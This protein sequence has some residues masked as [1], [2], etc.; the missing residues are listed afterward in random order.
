MPRQW[1]AILVLAAVVVRIAAAVA[2][3]NRFYFADET[4]YFDAAGRLLQGQGFGVAYRQAPAY[5]V[6]L[7]ALSVALPTSVLSL[8]VAQG[9]LGGLGA[10]V[11]F[12]ITER[13]AGRSPAL[14]AAAIYA[15]DPL[16]VVSAGLLYPETAAA[17]LLPLVVLAALRGS[18]D[19]LLG[20]TLVGILLG[21]TALLRP[22]ALILVPVL[23]GWSALAAEVPVRR[24]LAHL[25]VVLAGTLLVLAP[26]T[27]RNYRV[28]GQLA[29]IALAGTHMAPVP[30]EEVAREGLTLAI[31][32]KAWMDPAGLAGRTGR[33]FIQ[34]W[35]LAPT[36]LRTD[37]P[38]QRAALHQGEP[39]LRT[40]ALVPSRFTRLRNLASTLAST[41]EFGLAFLGLILLWRTQRRAALLISTVT[42]AF[43]LG[44]ALFVAKL[45]YR[46]PVLPLVFVLAGIGAW[47]LGTAVAGALRGK[48]RTGSSAGH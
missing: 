45:R 14:T 43:A 41:V 44:Y 11:V 5:P 39:R 12:A 3:G 38:A 9:V 7:A 25:G 32:R 30:Q 19:S 16:L 26:W 34:F 23:A 18:R 35:E 13:I 40:D 36:R 4:Y 31:L 6:L 37:D 2:I 42:F 17:V 27:Y 22:V 20:S 48:A 46:I 24:A 33:Q 1:L 21:S 8:R 29:P 28:Q 47:R 10:A 15:L